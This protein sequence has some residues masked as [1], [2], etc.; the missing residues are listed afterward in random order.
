M[1]LPDPRLNVDGREGP[2]TTLAHAAK[3]LCHIRS[4]WETSPLSDFKMLRSL[5]AQKSLGRWRNGE[6]VTKKGSGL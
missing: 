3:H 6:V 4:A 5:S 2:P 1:L